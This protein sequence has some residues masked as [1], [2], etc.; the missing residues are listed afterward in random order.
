SSPDYAAFLSSEGPLTVLRVPG[1]A[2]PTA[3]TTDGPL[4]VRAL[5]VAQGELDRPGWESPPGTHSGPRIAEDFAG[6]MRNGKPLGLVSGNW[7]AA[8]VSF[9]E[10]H[11]ARPGDELPHDYRA[12]VAELWADALQRGDARP[13]A[14]GYLP[15]QGDL[16]I[17]GRDGG[18]PTKGGPGHVGRL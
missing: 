5:A 16:A 13:A 3:P 11:A 18:D 4:G 12:A 9:C 7:W 2:A 6:C 10:A 8:F 17:F 1:V 15:R 14:T